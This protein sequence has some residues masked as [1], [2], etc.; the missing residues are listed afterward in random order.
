MPFKKR[1]KYPHVLDS[2]KHFS[3]CLRFPSRSS[4]QINSLLDTKKNEVSL[5]PDLESKYMYRSV[6]GTSGA[7]QLLLN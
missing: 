7:R 4:F 5:K 2:A 1:M 3:A 6:S